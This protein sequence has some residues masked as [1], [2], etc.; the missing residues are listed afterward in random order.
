MEVDCYAMDAVLFFTA[1]RP[2]VKV[3]KRIEER[4]MELR[5]EIH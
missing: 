4:R 2:S 5:E 1:L 3:R